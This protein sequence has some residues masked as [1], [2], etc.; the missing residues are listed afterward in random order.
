M[1]IE[2]GSEALSLADAYI[3]IHCHHTGANQNVE[4]INIA[5]Q[6]FNVEAAPNSF[7]SLGLHPWHLDREDTETA[8]SKISAANQN[9][10]LLAIGECGLDKAIATPLAV[11]T[12]A[13]LSQIKLAGQLGK[14]LIIHCVRTFN[15]LIQIKKSAKNTEIPWVIHGFNGNP[16]LATQ[17]I[18]H[19]FYLSFGAAL[20][21]P[22]SHAGK[23]LSRTP[24][25]RLFLETDAANVP[26]GAIYAAAAKM[27]GLD[28]A[29]LHQQILS[30]FKRVFL[31]D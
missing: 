23:A 17:L 22:H 24:A 29:I 7:F 21:N 15:E 11:Q 25:D 8:L 18:R 16:A 14:P 20:L 30:N 1:K 9:P 3:D 10:K 13:F 4:M 19:G 26:I 5:T 12:A 31:H 28:I 2:T 6:D 27:L